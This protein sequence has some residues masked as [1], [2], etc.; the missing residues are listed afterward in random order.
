MRRYYK[1]L[2][3]IYTML[4][5]YMMLFG[6]GREAGEVGNLQ[7]TPFH[8][9]ERFSSSYIPFKVFF[10]NI[11]CNIAVF[12]PFGWLGVYNRFFNPIY[13]IAPLFILSI[14]LVELIQHY[15]GRGIADVDDVILN[16]VGMLSG[17]AFYKLAD[18]KWSWTASSIK[19]SEVNL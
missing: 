12:A 17:Y 18:W 16:T 11:I 8:T 4:L 13:I 3:P 9:I 5:L 1:R 14:I 15:S 10:V 6:L 19:K 2:L 7:L